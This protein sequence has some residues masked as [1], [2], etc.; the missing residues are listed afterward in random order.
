VV[1]ELDREFPA[2]RLL[3]ILRADFEKWRR[4]DEKID[5]FGKRSWTPPFRLFDGEGSAV[6]EESATTGL[7]YRES[8]PIAP[9]LRLI[10]GARFEQAA[11]FIRSICECLRRP[12]G[13][14]LY[15]P[16]FREGVDRFL[17]EFGE[18]R[19]V[20]F[21][22]SNSDKSIMFFGDITAFSIHIW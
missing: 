11:L 6:L 3:A 9:G 20:A 2:E 16:T 7:T 14:I 22:L 1:I 19:S 5:A 18:K 10:E 8:I 15:E 4:G 12:G 13:P 21:Y 17:T